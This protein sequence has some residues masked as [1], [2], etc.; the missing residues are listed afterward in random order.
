M[1]QTTAASSA[2]SSASSSSLALWAAP[3]N[4][5]NGDGYR[6]AVDH[7]QKTACGNGGG[8]VAVHL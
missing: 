1:A 6:E 7:A 3:R 8:D 2:S 4:A 5:N